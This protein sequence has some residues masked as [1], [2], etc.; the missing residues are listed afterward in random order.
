ML[1]AYMPDKYQDTYDQMFEA[2]A[3]L[4]HE[5]GVYF[6]D[7]FKMLADWKTAEWN[8]FVN[9]FEIELGGCLFHFG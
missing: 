6:K 2:M 4:Q 8:G 9:N 1:Y 7:G 5:T 3:A